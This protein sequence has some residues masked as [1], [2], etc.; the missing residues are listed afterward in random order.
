MRFAGEKK[1]P[2]ETAAKMRFVRSKLIGIKPF[3]TGGATGKANKIGTVARGRNKQAA[4]DRRHLERLGPESQT[5]E[6]PFNHKRRRALGFAPGR[7]HA[8]GE[9]GAA[10]AG[11]GL[12]L[13]DFDSLTR[14]GEFIGRC[15]AGDASAEDADF[16]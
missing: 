14:S 8:A 1:G 5:F 16:F 4:V 3:V 15:E 2:V 10:A 13:D 12:A 6:S 11:R 7:Q 9:I